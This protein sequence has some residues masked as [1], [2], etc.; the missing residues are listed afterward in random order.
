MIWDMKSN[1][2]INN[3]MIIPLQSKLA[4]DLR[5]WSR[6]LFTKLQVHLYVSLSSQPSDLFLGSEWA[7]MEEEWA[8]GGMLRQFSQKGCNNLGKEG[9]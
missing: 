4:I 3:S 1:S 9:M 6:L 2:F 8:N 5:T 7:L